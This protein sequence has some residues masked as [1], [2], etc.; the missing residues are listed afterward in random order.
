MRI[1]W[2]GH[3]T[4][5]IERGGFTIYID[6]YL[7]PYLPVRLP[8]AN[9]ILISHWHPSHCTKESVQKLMSDETTIIG[10]I[11]ASRE[12]YG[13]TAMKAGEKKQVGDIVIKAMP[14]RTLHHIGGHS[15]EGF[16]IGFWIEIEEKKV[17]YTSD[18]DPL[19]EMIGLA[20]DVVIIPVGGTTTMGP[21]EAAKAVNAMQ[22][23][24]AIPAHWGSTT[25][26][27]DNAELFKELVETSPNQ[28]VV[29][30]EPGEMTEI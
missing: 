9:I 30:L 12:F 8:K 17:Y 29:I 22:A 25:G 5:L 27:R 13:C 6:P 18:T 24:I 23:K 14:A 7:D 4:F 28:K 3:S 15:E 1:T 16:I 2:L 21:E 10:T 11:D 26:T 20:P 19:P